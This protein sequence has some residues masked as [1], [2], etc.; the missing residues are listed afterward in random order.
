MQNVLPKGRLLLATSLIASLC[1]FASIAHGQAVPSIPAVA[2][3]TMLTPL[4]AIVLFGTF[5]A[6][7][8]SNAATTGKILNQ[9][10]LPI[11]VIP[12]L[13]LG[14]AFVMGALPVFTAATSLNATVV[15]NALVMGLVGMVTAAGGTAAHA[16]T[17]SH[18]MFKRKPADSPPMP[19]M[20]GAIAAAI[21]VVA[22]GLGCAGFAYSLTG[23]SLFGSV[24][25]PIAD[26]GNAVLQDADK[27]MTIEQI[28]VAVAPQ[29][30]LDAADIA[31]ILLASKDPNVVVSKAFQQAVSMKTKLTR[32]VVQ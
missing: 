21:G 4:S 30:A 27:G 5:L 3:I 10:N 32:T 7:F 6:G 11:T 28:L 14:A 26:C 19:R 31:V 1:L 25:A 17:Q 2:P 18:L 20:P 9:V 15:V 29:C 13:L 24:E 8:L 22:I 23:C 12:W 16:H